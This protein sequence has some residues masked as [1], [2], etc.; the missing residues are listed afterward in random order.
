ME[1]LLSSHQLKI[2]LKHALKKWERLVTSTVKYSIFNYSHMK[3]GWKPVLIWSNSVSNLLSLSVLLPGE[4]WHQRASERQSGL[5]CPEIPQHASSFL[6]RRLL[7]IHSPVPQR[8]QT[9]SRTGSTY[10]QPAAWNFGSCSVFYHPIVN[11]A[12]KK[13]SYWLHW[14]VPLPQSVTSPALVWL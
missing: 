10:T 3:D 2:H 8:R 9:R 12:S 11:M 1:G 13:D 14:M 7:I 4:E 5:Q 6:Y